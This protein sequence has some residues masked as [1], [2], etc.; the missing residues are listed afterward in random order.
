MKKF[1]IVNGQLKTIKRANHT[2]AKVRKDVH[3]SSGDMWDR[4]VANANKK[5]TQLEDYK[6]VKLEHFT[7]KTV[8][9]YLGEEEEFIGSTYRSKRHFE[10]YWSDKLMRDQA[11]PHEIWS[12]KQV[13]NL[14]NNAPE[15]WQIDAKRVKYDKGYR[16]EIFAYI[17]E[18]CESIGITIAQFFG[19]P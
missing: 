1:K 10:E 2:K 12:D 18:Y 9:E 7:R 3:R 11:D 16:D 14:L 13:K 5:V 17:D 8:R 15:G 6:G 4:I 19:S